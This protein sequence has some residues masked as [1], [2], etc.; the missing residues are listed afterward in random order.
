MTIIHT[1]F[2]MCLIELLRS[3][4]MLCGYLERIIS[5]WMFFLSPSEQC[6]ALK[7]SWST[8]TGAKTV[9][10]TVYGNSNGFEVKV[11]MHQS[12]ALS[13]LLFVIV[14]EVL[15]KDNMENRLGLDDIISVLQQNR[16]WCYGHVLRKEDNDW[17]KKY[18]EYKVE[19]DRPRGRPKKTWREI[20]WVEEC[21][22]WYWL[23]QVI[24][25]KIQRAV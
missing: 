23:I 8:D 16:L 7:G 21:F 25:D 17:V 20:V 15:E 14:V 1:M 5:G 19:G 18:M 3:S 2:N 12:S 6:M 9:V 4:E 13:P 11:G 22:F 10:R 24:P